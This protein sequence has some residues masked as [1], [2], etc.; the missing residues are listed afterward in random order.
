MTVPFLFAVL[1]LDRPELARCSSWS[2]CPEVAV[3]RPL[4][5]RLTTGT[6]PSPQG[7]TSFELAIPGPEE[8]PACSSYDGAVQV[9]ADEARGC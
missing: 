6:S 1:H 9:V 7:T 2:G 4:L 5:R 8:E 3:P